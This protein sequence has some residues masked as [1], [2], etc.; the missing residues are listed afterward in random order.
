MP[1]DRKTPLNPEEIFKTPL[2]NKGA[3]F[4]QKERD[5]L[6]LN[7]FLPFHTAS[8]EEQ[9]EKTYRNFQKIQAPLDKYLFLA[10]LQNRN[11][12]LFYQFTTQYITEVAP[13]IYTPTVG[14]AAVHFSQIY[15]WPRGLYLSYPLKDQMDEILA[16]YSRDAQVIVVTDGERILGLGDL[17][18][19][20]IT[21]PI[22]KLSL[23][24]LFG[25]IDPSKTLPIVLDVGTNNPD[26]LKD[27]YYAG[28]RQPRKSGPEYDAFIEQFVKAI[29]KRFP[30][31]LL[32]WE[33]FGKHNARRILDKYKEEILSFNDDI[34]GT[35]AV[36]L[37][38]L[39]AAVKKKD[40][41]LSEQRF[42][43][44]GGGSAG[45][46]IADYLTLAMQNEGLSKEEACSAIYIIDIEGLIHD[47]VK[48]IYE[49][50]KP[51]IKTSAALKNW[52]LTNP[53]E[54]S[55]MDVIKNAHPTVLIGVSGQGG[56]FTQ[57]M[58]VEMAKTEAKP[59][60]FPLSNPTSKTEAT[61]ENLIKWTQGQAILATGSPFD[62]VVYHGVIHHIGQC[63]NVYVF[64]GLGAGAIASDATKI[65]DTMFLE[66]AK[67]LSEFSPI[68]KNSNA[69]LFP[70]LSEVKKVCRQIA[71][72]VAKRAIQDG[73]SK[74]SLKEIESRLDALMWKSDRA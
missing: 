36:T 31:V 16:R 42:A 55:L 73:V 62:S 17:G 72:G 53:S 2:L 27:N 29:K 40:Q 34:Q 68:L 20:G 1:K 7:G 46:G 49:A 38:G 65:T 50:Q 57:E 48:N 41:K 28:W 5:D 21:I 56:A 18:V 8:E 44:L 71:I 4:T 60:I 45:T 47:G 19:G 24:T 39:F 13:I 32:Q 59:I 69:S 10:E 25:G 14:E 52:K 51:Y 35:A 66:A 9:I 11:E 33:D 22:G 15:S 67:V 3:A 23:Y 54:I 6:K 61:P 64:P 58:V 63:N 30:N 70:S 37:G 26:L 74:I 12:L 43:I